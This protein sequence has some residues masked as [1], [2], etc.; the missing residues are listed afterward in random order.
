MKTNLLIAGIALSALGLSAAGLRADAPAQAPTELVYLSQ[1]P[2][3]A[4]LMQTAAAEG[5]TVTKIDQVNGETIVTYKYPDGRINTVS[6]QLLPAGE[7]GATATVP[8]TTAVPVPTAAPTTTVVYQTASPDVYYAPYYY[9]N[10]PAY[11]PWGWYA[12]VGISLGF[13]FGHGGYHG[14]YRGGFRGGHW[15]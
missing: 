9:A 5:L 6:Y 10:G 3:P 8:A 2:T 7:A 14:G 13:G 12:P 11:Y 15:R 4:S 1:L